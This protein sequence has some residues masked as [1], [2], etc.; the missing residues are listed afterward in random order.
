MLINNKGSNL[1]EAN[2]N[3]I[4][5]FIT[6]S[7][8]YITISKH[9]IPILCLFFQSCCF[10][11]Y[12]W[13]ALSAIDK[14]LHLLWVSYSTEVSHAFQLVV[15]FW[16]RGLNLSPVWCSTFCKPN[17]KRQSGSKFGSVANPFKYFCCLLS[18]RCNY[19]YRRI[20]TLRIYH[21]EQIFGLLIQIMVQRFLT[22][23]YIWFV[24]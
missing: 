8:M 21:T 15:Y 24:K 9:T 3:S 20:W 14:Y 6:V 7:T 22:E 17:T 11:D 16:S 4:I 18:F 12:S 5:Y 13:S 2:L 23:K 19:N 10:F 1:R